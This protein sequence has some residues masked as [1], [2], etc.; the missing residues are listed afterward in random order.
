MAADVVCV[1]RRKVR[2]SVVMVVE[3]DPDVREATGLLLED[4]GYE[5]LAAE[6]SSQALSII[7]SRGDVDVVFT[8]VNLREDRNGIE[9]A[10]EIRARGSRAC[11]VVVS[12]DLG[13]SDTPLDDDMRFLAKPYGRRTLLEVVGDACGRARKE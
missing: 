5:V 6:S 11:F 2:M 7:Q 9:L 4:A 8:D 12:G 3:D 10:Q 13:W 1:A